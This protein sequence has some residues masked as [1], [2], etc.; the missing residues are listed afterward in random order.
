MPYTGISST[1]ISVDP[2]KMYNF[3]T[4][5]QSALAGSSNRGA[6]DLR[7][8]P[9]LVSRDSTTSLSEIGRTKKHARQLSN[10]SANVS[11]SDVR[12]MSVSPTQLG[13][14]EVSEAAALAPPRDSGAGGSDVLVFGADGSVRFSG[15]SERYGT[16]GE[17]EA[18]DIRS[19]S[20]EATLPPPYAHYGLN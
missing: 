12:A 5:S 9:Y 2:D 3:S 14:D 11:T 19:D 6:P 7:P 18:S 8:T 16:L 20:G 17:T 10:T 4:P 1:L 13:S 15:G